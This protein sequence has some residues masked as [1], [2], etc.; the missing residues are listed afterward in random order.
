MHTGAI[1]E[2]QN[3][4]LIDDLIAT[5]GTLAA[6]V[7]LVEQVSL[8]SGTRCFHA[9][10]KDDHPS[11]QYIHKIA[12]CTDYWLPLQPVCTEPELH[13]HLPRLP[14][15]SSR[16]LVDAWTICSRVYKRY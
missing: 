9:V 6:G 11:L 1:K 14:L 8:L 15:H 10:C 2:G 5:G 4:L 13:R 3:V 12:P 16:A 7:Q